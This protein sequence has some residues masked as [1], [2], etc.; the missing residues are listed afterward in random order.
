MF[1]HIEKGT[2][3]KSNAFVLKK[4]DEFKWQNIR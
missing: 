4:R 2:L 3:S 1:K